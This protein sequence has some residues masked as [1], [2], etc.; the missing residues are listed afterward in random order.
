M[1]DHSVLLGRISTDMP[2]QP[3]INPEAT[4]SFASIEHLK[5]MIRTG[6]LDLENNTEVQPEIEQI[7]QNLSILKAVENVHLAERE[8][9]ACSQLLK[10]IME[11]NGTDE[12]LDQLAGLADMI[13]NTA[14]CGLGMKQYV[15]DPT[16][17][18][19]CSRCAKQCPVDA[20]SGQIRSPFV[21]NPHKCI[22]CGSCT[23]TCAFHAISLTTFGYPA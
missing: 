7:F 6:V 3:E 2:S 14:L 21:I 16:V 12:E 4:A 18:K 5:Q 15:I 1:T 8:Q 9:N 22:R 10:K 20:I 11:G 23:D 17:C 13:T 19:G